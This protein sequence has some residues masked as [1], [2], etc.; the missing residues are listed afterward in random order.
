MLACRLGCLKNQHKVVVPIAVDTV[1]ADVR[2]KY[3]EQSRA[4]EVA[5]ERA[6][7]S[8]G[9]A[10]GHDAHRLHNLAA[11]LEWTDSL[12]VLNVHWGTAMILYKVVAGRYS[13]AVQTALWPSSTY[14]RCR[15]EVFYC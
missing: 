15:R 3:K 6:V 1:A 9:E 12:A 11:D 10:A 7:Q 14:R 5:V 2:K 13:V 4:T 8:G